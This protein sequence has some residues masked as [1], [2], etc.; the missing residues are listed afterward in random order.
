MGFLIGSQASW[1]TWGKLRSPIIDFYAGAGKTAHSL[2]VAGGFPPINSSFF[3]CQQWPFFSLGFIG[4]YANAGNVPASGLVPAYGFF[5]IHQDADPNDT[6]YSPHLFDDAEIQGV[7]VGRTVT[8]DSG[9][10][11]MTYDALNGVSGSYQT[12]STSTTSVVSF[13]L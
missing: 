10:V 5:Y 2:V 4:P 1:S 3:R 8:L 7:W 6:T 13:D 9:A 12:V 11:A